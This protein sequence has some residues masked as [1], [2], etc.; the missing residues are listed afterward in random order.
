M[1]V[2]KQLHKIES[3][4]SLVLIVEH[5]LEGIEILLEKLKEFGLKLMKKKLKS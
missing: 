1:K 4:C 3:I 2:T 5:S